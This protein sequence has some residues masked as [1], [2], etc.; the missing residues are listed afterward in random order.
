MH[1]NHGGI[2]ESHAGKDCMW[3]IILDAELYT[4]CPGQR[5]LAVMTH[6]VQ[7]NIPTFEASLRKIH[8]FLER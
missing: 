3:P 2:S 4:T 8:F 1:H 7:R 5:M 6:P